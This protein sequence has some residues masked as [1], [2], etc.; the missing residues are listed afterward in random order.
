MVVRNKTVQVSST[1]PPQDHHKKPDLLRRLGG[2]CRLE[3]V[4]LS[5]SS[6]IKDDQRLCV[7][8]DSSI[9]VA[10]LTAHHSEFLSVVLGSEIAPGCRAG[11]ESFVSEQHQPFFE[12]G[13]NESHFDI[14]IQ[15]FYTTLEEDSETEYDIIDDAVE[16]LSSFR[17][18]FV[19]GGRKRFNLK[20][21]KEER[22]EEDNRKKTVSTFSADRVRKERVG[23]SRSGEGLLEKFRVNSKKRNKSGPCDQQ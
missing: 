11:V 2:P 19:V 20:I 5:L 3:S 13:W 12:K 23:R 9:D 15:H 6:R 1:R 22:S 8:F 10:N 7:F 18:L 14:V 4:A 17:P 21:K 16:V